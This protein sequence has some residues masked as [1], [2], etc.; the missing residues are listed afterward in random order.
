MCHLL[1]GGQVVEGSLLLL[2][3]VLGVLLGLISHLIDGR[4]HGLNGIQCGPATP[5]TKMSTNFKLADIFWRAQK[6]EFQIGGKMTFLHFFRG[7]FWVN[8]GPMHLKFKSA[9]K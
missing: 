7:G 4:L 1:G 8:H 3:Q 9:R 5:A 2:G 6:F